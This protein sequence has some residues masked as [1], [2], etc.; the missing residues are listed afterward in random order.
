MAQCL[1]IHA[2]NAECLGLIHDQ[3]ID[4]PHALWCSKKKKKKQSL[5]IYSVL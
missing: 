5:T 4:I 2:S 3:E 1:V